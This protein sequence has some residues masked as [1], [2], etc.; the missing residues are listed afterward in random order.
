MLW[1]ILIVVIVFLAYGAHGLR[2]LLKFA[3]A[4][5]ALAVIILT[6]YGFWPK[7]KVPMFRPTSTS[8]PVNDARLENVRMDRFK[9]V[10]GEIRNLTQEHTIEELKVEATA[11]D[12]PAGKTP[13]D[14]SPAGELANLRNG[15]SILHQ[16]H[17]VMGE[18]TR[19]YTGTS[20]DAGY[21]DVPTAQIE[22][23]EPAPQCTIIGQESGPVFVNLPPGQV[24]S[25]DQ[26]LSWSNMGPVHGQFHWSYVVKSLNGN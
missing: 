15:F 20:A 25:F 24:R 1:I 8:L 7:S 14:V 23:Y 4:L 17:E 6:G 10:I 18:F 22:S 16:R 12:C 13:S 21:I 3:L 26:Y 11:W 19:L 5:T 9:H 2:T